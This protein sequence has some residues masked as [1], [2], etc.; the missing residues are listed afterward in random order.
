MDSAAACG[1]PVPQEWPRT[2]L[3]RRASG[4]RPT[5]A[6]RRSALLTAAAPPVLSDEDDALPSPDAANA[7]CRR[8]K[9]TPGYDAV[10]VHPAAF[11]YASP[12]RSVTANRDVED[13]GLGIGDHT[14]ATLD[15]ELS[16]GPAVLVDLQTHHARRPPPVGIAG[17]DASSKG[18]PNA[19]APCSFT[20]G[21]SS[22][23]G[24]LERLR[25]RM[26]PCLSAHETLVS[27]SQLQRRGQALTD[28]AR[29]YPDPTD[30]RSDEDFF[31]DLGAQ[32]VALD[33]SWRHQP[34]NA[35]AS[36]ADTP[37]DPH[38]A[39]LPA[40][41]PIP[42]RGGPPVP[43]VSLGALYLS[44]SDGEMA[45]TIRIS[46]RGD[47]ETKMQVS[48]HDE[49][50]FWLERTSECIDRWRRRG[51]DVDVSVRD[52]KGRLNQSRGVA[53]ILGYFVRRRL[54]LSTTTAAEAFFEAA[55]LLCTVW[56]GAVAR[57]LATDAAQLISVTLEIGSSKQTVREA[58][59]D[60]LA[61]AEADAA[62]RAAALEKIGRAR[63]HR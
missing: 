40:Q 33:R 45:S 3:A 55:R 12:P 19:S 58:A 42:R 54:E 51:D 4:C 10:G 28:P 30:P 41:L 47:S 32:L 27:V 56:P 14:T 35:D 57:L 20:T 50:G 11:T 8:L 59:V 2:P 43:T 49:L 23:D 53:L 31:C 6:G 62:T 48:P 36:T 46:V 29:S 1:A 21:E 26:R 39:L 24:A 34:H 18:A 16:T 9:A 44:P 52:A 38:G 15:D 37:P 25:Q 13:P 61:A 5:S 60:W 22:I 63:A 17:D 7:R